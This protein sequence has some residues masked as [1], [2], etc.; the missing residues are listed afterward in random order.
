MYHELVER[1]AI[2]LA[3]LRRMGSPRYSR[4]QSEN[5]NLFKDGGILLG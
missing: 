3:F 4:R 1:L 5:E 2:V